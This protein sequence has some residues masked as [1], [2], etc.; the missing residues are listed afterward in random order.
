VCR[1]ATKSS[2]VLA[3][4]PIRCGRR[5]SAPCPVTGTCRSTGRP[6]RCQ[7]GPWTPG[8]RERQGA[9]GRPERQGSRVGGRS[10]AGLRFSAGTRPRIPFDL[11]R[12]APTEDPAR[13]MSLR[14]GPGGR[15]FR[16][17]RSRGS[18]GAG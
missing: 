15:R 11:N 8:R 13:C 10:V 3:S 7:A 14:P 1:V 5:A 12:W 6:H 17:A 4:C 16:S 18:L 2:Q 9:S